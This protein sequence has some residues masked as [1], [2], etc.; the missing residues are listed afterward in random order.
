MHLLLIATD[1]RFAGLVSTFMSMVGATVHWVISGAEAEPALRDGEHDCVVLERSLPDIDGVDVLRRIRQ[2]GFDHPLVVI[3]SDEAMQE[4]IRMLDL[5]ADDFLVKPVHL[6]ELGA[7]LRALLRRRS[8]APVDETMLWH[9]ELRVSTSSR[10]VARGGQFVAL[11]NKEFWLL[12]TLLRCKGR[13][14][15]RQEL[16]EALHCQ[17]SDADS[18]TV[19]V[20]VHHLRRK[21]GAPLIKTVRGVGYTLGEQA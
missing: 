17:W 7:R 19:E 1:H 2:S 15:G 12:E 13:V 16:E 18:N 11:T 21:L 4:R 6:G 9:G 8:N 5:G 20:H 14:L 3:S 10:T